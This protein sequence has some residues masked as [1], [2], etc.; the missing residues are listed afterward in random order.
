MSGD[1]YMLN[2]CV[3]SRPRG[4]L[5][6][7]FNLNWKWPAAFMDNQRFELKMAS[8]FYGQP[9]LPFRCRWCRLPVMEEVEMLITRERNINR[10]VFHKDDPCR[11]GG[12][13]GDWGHSLPYFDRASKYPRSHYWNCIWII[14]LGSAQLVMPSHN[15]E[16]SSI[17][18]SGWMIMI[19]WEI[20]VILIDPLCFLETRFRSFLR[21]RPGL[22]LGK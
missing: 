2:G 14:S 22:F 6:S 3:R 20:G 15:Q 18:V 17:C 1:E 5:C 9:K 12:W 13:R 4:T 7:G 10:P 8:C 16:Y 21:E 19:C 11:G